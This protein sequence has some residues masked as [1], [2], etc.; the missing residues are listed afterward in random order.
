MRTHLPAWAEATI[1]AQDA[2]DLRP[3]LVRR[4]HEIEADVVPALEGLNDIEKQWVFNAAL[5]A[6]KYWRL[7]AAKRHR[8]TIAAAQ[9]RLARIA[10]LANDLAAHLNKQDT[11]AESHGLS[12]GIPSLW[13]L[14]EDTAEA[15]PD[16]CE[17]LTVMEGHGHWRD[18]IHTAQTQSRHDPDLAALLVALSSYIKK[19]G[20]GIQSAVMEQ[21]AISTPKT[22]ALHLR[23]L[24]LHLRD[25]LAYPLRIRGFTLPDQAIATLA[26]VLFDLDPPPTASSISGLRT[27]I[28]KE[29]NGP[30]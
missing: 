9:K 11:V 1:A 14:L 25:H 30:V 4:W 12:S 27:R 6:G 8:K 2:D 3:Q 18:F 5:W 13:E 21:R 7:E 22:T 26:A 23:I 10:K 28:K 20:P 19:V 15:K 17:W 29:K 24:I 16:Y